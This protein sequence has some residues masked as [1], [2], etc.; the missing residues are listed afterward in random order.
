[1]AN[2]FCVDT[3]NV[4]GLNNSPKRRALFNFLQRHKIDIAYLQETY[5]KSD[6]IHD[7]KREWREQ[8]F[9]RNGTSRSNGLLILIGTKLI[10]KKWN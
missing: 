6:T 9:H 3:L 1:M 4:R 10:T 8:V 7:I 2:T 5:I